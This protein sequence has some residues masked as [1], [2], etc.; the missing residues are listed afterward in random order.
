[1]RSGRGVGDQA[2]R[3]VAGAG[4]QHL[5]ARGLER[6]A[7]EA[8]DLRL[9]VDDE[10]ARAAHG[11]AL[12]SSGAS[13][14]GI[15]MTT[16]VPRRRDRRAFRPDAAAHR[17]DQ[18]AADGKAEAGAGLAPVGAAAAI[19]FLEDALEVGRLDAR[20]L[21][22][23]GNAAPS[24]PSRR[25]WTLTRPPPPYFCALSSRLNST[26][27]MQ[28]GVAAH[29]RQIARQ[30][31]REGLAR[32]RLAR[33][34]DRRAH[35]FGDVDEIALRPQ[36]AGLDARHVEQIGD[37]ARQPRRFLLDRGEQVARA[38][39]S[40]SRRRTCC[41]VVTAP[42][43]VASG[44]RRS[45]DSEAS[46]VVRSFSFSSSATVRTE[47]LTSSARSIGDRR[48]FE[49]EVE[50]VLERRRNRRDGVGR[51]EAADADDAARRH[52]RTELEAHVRQGAGLPARRLA[53]LEGPAR[54]AGLARVER[55]D[56]RPGGR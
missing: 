47:A 17:L 22:G 25:A 42:V 53:L 52:Q 19:E 18:P 1:M 12:A 21:V 8:Q 45:C 46:R 16:R 40:A 11:A 5:I 43:I 27:S 39:P 15:A 38:A 37:E 14:A 10:D 20:A 29:E 2:Q 41:S 49:N 24:A 6:R 56:R 26:C 4:V 30:A 48:L 55:V 23:D 7:Q 13:A 54:G 34:L 35:D 51:L 31:G 44:V 33:A 32:E 28:V 36:G 9:V 50:R 3:L